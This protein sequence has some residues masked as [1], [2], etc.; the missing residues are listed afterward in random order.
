MKGQV[1]N[2]EIQAIDF[3]NVGGNFGVFRFAAG[4]VGGKCPLG[5]VCG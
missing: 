4:H 1:H 5:L 2:Y 3:R